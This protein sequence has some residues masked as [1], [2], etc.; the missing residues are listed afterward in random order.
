MVSVEELITGV[1]I[2]LAVLPVSACPAFDANHND[3]VTIDELLTAVNN[4]LTTCP[5]GS[6]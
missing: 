5:A 2:A 4:A 1:D 3:A 6:D